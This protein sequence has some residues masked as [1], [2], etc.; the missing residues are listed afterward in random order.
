MTKKLNLTAVCLLAVLT[1]CAVTPAHRDPSS[2]ISSK[3]WEELRDLKQ[4]KVELSALSVHF[5]KKKNEAQL[6]KIQSEQ[7][8]IDQKISEI[9]GTLTAFEDRSLHSIQNQS[10]DWRGEKEN[11]EL[12]D[13]RLYEL[14]KNVQFSVSTYE[15]RET[16]V[17]ISHNFFTKLGMKREDDGK[18]G[19]VAE[20]NPKKAAPVISFTIKCDA[21][22]EVKLGTLTKKLKGNKDFKFVL[23]DT[24]MSQGGAKE[25]KFHKDMNACAVRFAS[26]LDNFKKEYGFSI[27]NETK[28]LKSLESL[29]STTEVCSLK[30]DT[31]KFFDTTEFTSM[32][33][34]K[35]YD[36]I[37]IL[38]E[39]EDSL[40]ARA[41]ALTGKDLPEDF[42]KN[43]NPYAELDFSKAPKFDAILV[44]YL[45]FRADFYGTLLGRLLAY[46]ADRGAVVR[47]LVSDV[48]ALDKD[49]AMFEKLMAEHPNMKVVKYRF[50]TSEKGG[51]WISEFHRTNH[52]KI[53]AGYSKENPQDSF[54][55]VGGRNIHDG[56]VF[57]KPVD[58]SKFPEVVSYQEGGDESWAYWRDFEMVI[59][60]QDFIESV[61][62]NYMNF[63][64]I[65]KDNLTMKLSSVAIHKA[66][67]QDAEEESLRHYVSIPF[68]DEPN[69][70]LFYARM[71][72]TAKKKIL[73]SSP[74][75][76]PVKEIGEALDRA[77][78]RGVD[79]TII[80][81][82]DLEGDTADFILG[83]VN[84]DGVNRFLDKVK[85]YEYT[86]PKV[87]LH[88]KL[89]MVDD[90]F[91]FISSVNLNKRSFYHDLENG[92]V[93]NDSN[94][95][96]QM[97]S[98]YKEYMK[99]SRQ[100]TEQQKIIFWKKWI[101]TIFDKVL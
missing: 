99:I 66:N 93:V 18:R 77:I 97:G 73:I 95:T 26:S 49:S 52:V 50:D 88:S 29:L 10:V 69:L 94:F 2:T 68:K 82:L 76:R 59:H 64:H 1:G 63:Y 20:N 74:Y 80:T 35:K 92:V 6:K 70:N 24:K 21:P 37:K 72:D 62:R 87:I 67:A 90:E 89:L 91:S 100:L 38:P 53:F 25:F 7:K 9:E 43:G 33:C 11:L 22:S 19:K 5:Q 48:I 4:R 55:I 75:F 44:S 8:N 45:V 51:A 65:N 12:S 54:A 58:V 83:A 98:L 47:I 42:V 85:V 17:R 46:H 34:P 23:A 78:Q 81:R 28:K 39:P 32:T 57:K 14:N 36:S 16:T 27:V 30:S 40:H 86:E 60:G 56:F 61:V 41:I 96:K 71:V 84:K 13:L 3:S 101:I 79:I 31:G 15:A